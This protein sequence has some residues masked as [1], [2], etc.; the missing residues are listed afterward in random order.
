MERQPYKFRKGVE[1]L[2]ANLRG[3][4]ENVEGEAPKTDRSLASVVDRILAKYKI[5]AESLEDR[6]N[7]R[8][9]QI[10]GAANAANCAPSRIER[11]TTLVIAVANPVIRQELEFNKRLILKNLH[12]IPEARKI[13]TLVFRAG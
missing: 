6:I 13:R 8:W 3:I 5:G 1:K 7:E 12:A 9:P 11:D 4:P 10:V 2:I